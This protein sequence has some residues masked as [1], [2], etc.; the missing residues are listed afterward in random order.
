MATININGIT[1]T[2]NSIN[3]HNGN[4]I[5][6]GVN[7]SIA[8]EQKTITI[9]VTG[10]VDRI[11]CD[12]CSLVTVSGNSGSVKTQSG[13]VSVGGDVS[14]DAK[15]MSGDINVKGSI[16]GGASTMSGDIKYNQ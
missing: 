6:D 2:G 5:V 10:N 3:I 11:E 1:Y 13:N 8:P 12:V 7:V 4:V 15:T 9:E 14:G 16:K